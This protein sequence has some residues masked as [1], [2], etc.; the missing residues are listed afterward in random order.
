MSLLCMRVFVQQREDF[1]CSFFLK[2]NVKCKQSNNVCMR[3]WCSFFKFCVVAVI[4]YL[5]ISQI[6]SNLHNMYDVSLVVK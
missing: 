1:L 2:I 3:N 4:I 5:H 6:N